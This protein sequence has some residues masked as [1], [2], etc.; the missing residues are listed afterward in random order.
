MRS[1][2]SPNTQNSI[3]ELSEERD[4]EPQ[5][6]LPKP[7]FLAPGDRHSPEPGRPRSRAESHIS[8]ASTSAE[9]AKEAAGDMSVMEVD[10]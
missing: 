9:D 3:R 8:K 5:G 4:D 2:L 7:D 10:D 6:R 1:S